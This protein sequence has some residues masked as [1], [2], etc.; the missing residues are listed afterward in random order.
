MLVGRGGTEYAEKVAFE[1]GHPQK[2]KE[3]SGEEREIF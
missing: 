2:L 1:W 3:K